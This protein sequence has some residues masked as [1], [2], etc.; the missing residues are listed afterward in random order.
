MRVEPVC[1]IL[2]DALQQVFAVDDVDRPPKAAVSVVGIFGELL[3]RPELPGE[4]APEFLQSFVVRHDEQFRLRV[5][6]ARRTQQRVGED[7]CRRMRCTQPVGEDLRD[8]G[9]LEHIR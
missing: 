8:Q 7:R 3:H 6:Q 5:E 9:S 1:A 2:V 4:V